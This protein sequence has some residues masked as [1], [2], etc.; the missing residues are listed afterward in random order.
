MNEEQIQTDV[1]EDLLTNYSA[2]RQY[3]LNEPQIGTNHPWAPR[4]TDDGTLTGFDGATGVTSTD[5]STTGLA[6]L[7]ISSFAGATLAIKQVDASL[8]VAEAIRQ[9]LP[10]LSKA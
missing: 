4:G 8:P 1:N 10:L 9:C 7:D 5:T 2:F 3:L 6:S